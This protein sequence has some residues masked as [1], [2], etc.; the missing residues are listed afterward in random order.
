MSDIRL[1]TM[2]MEDTGAGFPIVM[3]HGLGGTSTNFEPLLAA[4]DG[5]RVLRPDL[6]GAGRSPYRPGRPDL[7]GLLSAARDCV[8]AAGIDRAHFVGHSMGTLICQHLAAKEPGLVVSLALFGPILEPP[9][10]ARV[11]LKERAETARR[12]GMSPIADAVSTGSVAEASRAANPIVHAYVRES[13]LRQDPIGYAA[14]CEALASSAP[15]P[16][17]SVTCPTR[18]IVGERDPV[19]PPSMAH[20]LADRLPDATTTI[21]AGVSHWMMLED[22]P[23]SRKTLMQHLEQAAA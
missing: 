20:R 5:Y 7:A 9:P 1:G 15:A 13:L 3:I 6:P 12:D 4:L 16:H 21:L 8:R 18:L 11:A 23:G 19:A 2:V 10:P 22:L 14:H 17:A